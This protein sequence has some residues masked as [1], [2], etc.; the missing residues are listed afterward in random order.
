MDW[1][2]AVGYQHEVIHTGVLEHLLNGKS[3]GTVAQALL[4]DEAP[5]ILNVE[6]C[7]REKRMPGKRRPIDLAATLQ[8]PADQIGRAHV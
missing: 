6:G 3:R 1:V 2:Q 5:A 4:G 7:T 8:L